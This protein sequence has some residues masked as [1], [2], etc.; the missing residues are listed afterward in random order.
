MLLVDETITVNAD[1]GETYRWISNHENYRRWYPGV[2][3]VEA[4][5]GL[6][7]GAVGKAYRE[8]LD[9]GGARPVEMIIRVVDAVEPTRFV[10]ESDL[11]RWLTRM[12]VDLVR[13]PNGGIDVRW[14]FRLRNRFSL[15]LLMF[16][17]AAGPRLRRR[18]R[19]GLSKLKRLIETE[20]P[21]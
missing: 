5:D 16:R 19:Q 3:S 14:R 1:L 10:T 11:G 8:R 18:S 4:M 12:E 9:V 21:N 15:A 20:Q 2:A 13:L 7:H 17:F 6:P